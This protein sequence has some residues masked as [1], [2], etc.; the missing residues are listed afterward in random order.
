DDEDEQRADDV[1]DDHRRDETGGDPADGPDAADEDEQ[2]AGAEHDTGDPGLDAEG[3]LE[4]A[5]H[6]VALCHV[7]DPEGGDDRGDGERQ[8][9]D[10]AGGAADAAREGVLRAAGPLARGVW[11]AG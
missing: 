5:G 10:L 2:G 3:A 8:P 6:R 4:V 9:E 11:A 7:A 1:E